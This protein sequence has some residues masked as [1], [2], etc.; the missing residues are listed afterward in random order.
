M[1]Y[2]NKTPNYELPQY[3]GTDK[4]TYLEDMNGAYSTID[5]TMKSNAQAAAAAQSTADTNT[6]AISTLD[7]Q[8][9]GS[10]GIAARVSA[11]ET[12]ATN[13]AGAVNTINSLIGDGTP[14]TTAQTIIPAI[15][16]LDAD[17]NGAGGTAAKVTA[18]ETKV[19][20][21]VLTTTAPDLCGAVNELNAK[22]GGGSV[23]VTADGVKTNSQ[24]LDELYALVDASKVSLNST[25]NITTGTSEAIHN[26]NNKTATLYSYSRVD[27]D[28]SHLRVRALH[29]LA[30]SS[31]YRSLEDTT[32]TDVSSS[33][34]SAGTVFTITY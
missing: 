7:T 21:A 16:E 15:N 12:Q 4:P 31:E 24:L 6:T 9:N 27:A 22:V 32:V 25:L 29:V 10:G 26:M 13:T 33:I 11:V 14:T 28:S 19:G 34:P 17:L 3:I 8:V 23:Y 20:T 2:T 1:S 30:S 5:T 18:L